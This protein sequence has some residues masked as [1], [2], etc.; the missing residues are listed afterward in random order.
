LAVIFP[1]TAL[2][3]FFLLTYLA[4]RRYLWAADKVSRGQLDTCLYSLTD[5][6]DDRYLV[7]VP[8]QKG[9]RRPYKFLTPESA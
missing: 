1:A 4:W 3:V 2:A 7:I 8:H 6:F 9:I 5:V